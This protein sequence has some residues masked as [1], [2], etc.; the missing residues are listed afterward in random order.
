MEKVQEEAKFERKPANQVAERNIGYSLVTNMDDG[1]HLDVPAFLRRS[2]EGDESTEEL[3][4]YGVDI[5][6]ITALIA[7]G[8]L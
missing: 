2:T 5:S 6:T 7:K 1:E 3:E 8:P 4:N